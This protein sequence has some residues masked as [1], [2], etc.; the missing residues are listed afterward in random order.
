VKIRVRILILFLACIFLS[1]ALSVLMTVFFNR[2]NGLEEARELDARTLQ[3]LAGNLNMMTKYAQQSTCAVLGNSTVQKALAGLETGP[4][5]PEIRSDVI[6]CLAPLIR[7]GSGIA[8]VFFCDNCGNSCSLPDSAVRPRGGTADDAARYASAVAADGDWVCE[9][10]DGSLSLCQNG[11][12]SIISMIRLVK[13]EQDGGACGM[14]MVSI[15]AETVRGCFEA[16]GG[17]D[18]AYYLLSGDTLALGP[19][20]SGSYAENRE[21][22]CSLGAGESKLLRSAAGYTLCQKAAL[23]MDGWFLVSET[24]LHRAGFSVNTCQMLLIL[25]ANVALLS[26]CWLVVTRYVSRPLHD[27]E[28]HIG[29]AEGI[30]ADFPVLPGQNDEIGNLKRAY[31]RMLTAIRALLRQTQ[32]EKKQLQCS[33]LEL[34][35]SQIN[36]H[37]LYNTLGTISGMILSGDQEQSF[38]LVQALGLFYRNNLGSGQQ[39]IALSDEVETIRSYL[40]ILNARYGGLIRPVFRVEEAVYHKKILRFL[41]QP[42]VENAV[43]HGL[44]PRGNSGTVAIGAAEQDG[45]LLLSVWDSGVGMTPEKMRDVMHE[46]RNG[47]K[48]FGLLSVRERVSLFYGADG[49]VSLESRVGKWTKVTIRIPAEGGAWQGGTAEDP[50]RG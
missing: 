4:M 22:L 16:A 25:A 19:E 35:I 47:R 9:T 10:G 24:P 39:M 5:T 44:R 48:G 30:P 50:D 41:L 12:R 32:E 43:A 8:S 7:P 20:D 38:Q 21:L 26:V 40:S 46:S 29:A 3:T 18:S 31:N 45:V 49:S 17:S 14:L 37:F 1:A 15:D 13:S 6:D 2:R 28:A 42:L 11:S 36:P 33:E 34:V 23:G 27:M